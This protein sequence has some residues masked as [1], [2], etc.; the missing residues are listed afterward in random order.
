MRFITQTSIT[1]H[2]ALHVYVITVS[3]RNFDARD[4]VDELTSYAKFRKIRWHKG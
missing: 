1:I 2:K 3:Y 4:Y